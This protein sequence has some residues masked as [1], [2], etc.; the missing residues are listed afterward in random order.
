MRKVSLVACAIRRAFRVGLHAVAT[1]T[2]FMVKLLDRAQTD[3]SLT[4]RVSRRNHRQ[5]MQ[6]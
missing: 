5:N 2:G 6:P 3:E 1:T 4:L